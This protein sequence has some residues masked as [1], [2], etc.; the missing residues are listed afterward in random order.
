MTINPDKPVSAKDSA[1]DAVYLQ[2]KDDIV[3]GRLEG[4]TALRQDDIARANGVSKIPVREA[5]RRLEMEGLVVFRP[6]RGAIVRRLTETEILELLDVR[7]ALECRAL[8]LAIPN[9]IASDLS[10]ARE[11]LE[12]YETE[13]SGERWSTLN[14]KFHRTLYAPCSNRYLLN[15]ID[16]L[17]QRMGSFMRLRVTQASGQERPHGEHIRMLDA[18]AVGDGEAAVSELHRHIE[19]TKKEVAAQFRRGASAR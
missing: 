14:L 17:E 6:R 1:S 12:E 3:S 19:T 10:I 16:E 13:T 9:M 7:I 4:G 2:L 8:E 5:L 18:C 11:I 15:L